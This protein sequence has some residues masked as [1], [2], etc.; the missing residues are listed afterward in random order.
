MKR[1][2]NLRFTGACTEQRSRT[3]QFRTFYC[4]IIPSP[5]TNTGR[6]ETECSP[7]EKDLW[8]LVDGNPNL[9]YQCALK[10]L[11]CSK[12]SVASGGHGST[13]VLLSHKTPPGV[14]C[15]HLGPQCNKYVDLLERGGHEDAQ[16]AGSP[17]WRQAETT[18]AVPPGEEKASDRTYSTLPYLQELGATGDLERN[19]S[20]GMEGCD[21]N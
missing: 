20:K 3:K 15:S 4:Q 1:V 14:L 6:V 5:S 2:Q 8:I 11:G 10:A 7:E 18:R 17:L 19:Y 13:P 12:S 16:R 21:K 9:I